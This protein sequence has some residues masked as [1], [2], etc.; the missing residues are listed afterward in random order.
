[1]GVVSLTGSLVKIPMKKK[2]FPENQALK[3]YRIANQKDI[4]TWQEA[5][6]REDS[7]KK[8][9]RTIAERLGLEM[10]IT[11]VEFQGDGGKATFY[12]TA[13]SRVDFRL[14]I[15]EFANIFRTKIDMKQLVSGKK[16]RKLAASALA[17]ESCVA[18]LGL[19]TSDL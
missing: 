10:K 8:D 12:Y 14:L 2:N 7:V 17:V 6:K 16:P 4:E 9:A 1:M 5:R 11:D 18:P 15:K 19:Q 3:I 13:D